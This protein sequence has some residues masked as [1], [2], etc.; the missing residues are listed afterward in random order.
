M[1]KQPKL[2]PRYGG[3]T[4]KTSSGKQGHGAVMAGKA[5]SGRRK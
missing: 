2:T 1:G 4:H 3:L 5:K